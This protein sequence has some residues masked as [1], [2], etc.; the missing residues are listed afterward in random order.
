VGHTDEPR[1]SHARTPI[2]KRTGA[3]LAGG[4]AGN[5]SADL[6]ATHLERLTDEIHNFARRDKLGVVKAS[7]NWHHDELKVR[8]IRVHKGVETRNDMIPR[9]AHHASRREVF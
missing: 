9:I 3:P 7:E 2:P 1:N 6:K 4:C 5:D 8:V